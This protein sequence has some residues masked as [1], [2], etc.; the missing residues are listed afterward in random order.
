MLDDLYDTYNRKV[1]IHPDPLEV[2]YRF[3]DPA[4]RE[5]AGMIAS[6]LAFGRVSLILLTLDRV[7]DVIGPSPSNYLKRSDRAS[8]TA[9]F[10]GF[11]YRFVR[12]RHL[13]DFL[14]GLKD[15]IERFGTLER[16]AAAGL[17]QNDETVVPAM[18]NLVRQMLAGG[19]DPG[20]LLAA[21]SKQ[22]ACKR[23]NLFFRWMVRKDAVDPGTW[24]ALSPRRLIVPLDT[25]MHRIAL[26][27]GL[28]GRRS[29]DMKTA[30]D[31]T[32]SFA[33]VCP[34]DP[35]K[36][37]FALTRFGIHPDLELRALLD[38]EPAGR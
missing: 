33:A 5:I 28:T 3:D 22:S 12:D 37:D 1:F 31:I 34:E 10:D 2:V 21:P 24:T 18:D 14:L 36:Y 26:H 16:A 4:D 25:H 13:V 35:V 23:L 17:S 8:L 7:L 38:R 29:A 11:V 30:R 20:Y 27:L 15:V 19:R 9:D 32:R 6:A